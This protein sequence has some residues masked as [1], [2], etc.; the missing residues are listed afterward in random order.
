M[1]HVSKTLFDNQ[2]LSLANL[3]YTSL[4]CTTNIYFP[5]PNDQSFHDSLTTN[6]GSEKT[7]LGNANIDCQIYLSSGEQIIRHLNTKPLGCYYS[8]KVMLLPLGV[9]VFDP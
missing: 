6:F 5:I 2:T 8:E 9:D 1:W 4:V 3:W 7:K